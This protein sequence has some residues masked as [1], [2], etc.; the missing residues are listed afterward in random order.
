MF[1]LYTNAYI[2]SVTKQKLSEVGRRAI[3]HSPV[4]E[5]DK[6]LSA[7]LRC[8]LSLYE[9]TLLTCATLHVNVQIQGRSTFVAWSVN[10]ILCLQTTRNN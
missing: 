9:N 6:V 4:H 8:V 5:L 1:D 2:T 10:S 7:V 3:S